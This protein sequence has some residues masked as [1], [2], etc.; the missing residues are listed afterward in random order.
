MVLNRHDSHD[1]S[2]GVLDVSTDREDDGKSMTKGEFL[3]RISRPKQTRRKQVL[4]NSM[5][6]HVCHCGDPNHT[7][8]RIDVRTTNTCN[9]YR[10]ARRRVGAP[11]LASGPMGRDV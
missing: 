9:A 5:F 10:F 4:N 3:E 7:S 11:V 2:L 6:S 8:D 1:N